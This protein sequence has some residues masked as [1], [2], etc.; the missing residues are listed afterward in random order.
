MLVRV[1]QWF[2]V[3]FL[4]S[5]HSPEVFF[6]QIAVATYLPKL[7]PKSFKLFV[8]FFSTG[9]MER[10]TRP[11]EIATANTLARL[12]STVPSCAKGPAQLSVFDIHTLQVRCCTATTSARDARPLALLSLTPALCAC[13]ATRAVS[14]LLQRQRADPSDVCHSAAAG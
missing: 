3:G 9:T 2:H 5:F 1:A 14:V 10:V 13:V 12:L 6:E 4:A 8:P 11:G 7:L